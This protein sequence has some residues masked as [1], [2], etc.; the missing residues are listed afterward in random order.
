MIL[1]SLALGFNARCCFFSLLMISCINCHTFYLTFSGHFLEIWTPSWGSEV[2]YSCK[3][4]LLYMFSL[5]DARYSFGLWLLFRCFIYM[6]WWV[7]C[8]WLSYALKVCL[9][10]WNY[11]I[12]PVTWNEIGSLFEGL[13][14]YFIL[15]ST[16][17]CLGSFANFGI[18]I[19][20]KPNNCWKII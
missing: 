18:V 10:G 19:T 8:N 9:S 1:S 13:V 7:V 14:F 3:K 5:I 16:I 4:S 12:K 2:D 11:A 20:L 6:I 17:P 15:I